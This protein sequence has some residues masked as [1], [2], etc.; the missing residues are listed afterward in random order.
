MRSCWRATPSPISCGSRRRP[1]GC[2]RLLTSSRTSSRDGRESWMFISFEAP[3]RLLREF[4]S[5]VH[6]DPVLKVALD[7]LDLR[8]VEAL[9]AGSHV[10]SGILER[11]DC[12]GELPRFELVR[13]ST[14]VDELGL[15]FTLPRLGSGTR[16]GA[17]R[18]TILT[19]ELTC[20]D[21]GPR[22]MRLKPG[23]G[24]EG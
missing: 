8:Q 6:A 14:S 15:P 4:L 18:S 24:P 10:R 17:W 11:T 12:S 16:Q 1:G 13:I 20:R 23:R 19:P 21:P 7:T 9:L 5:T 2:F 22:R 3:E